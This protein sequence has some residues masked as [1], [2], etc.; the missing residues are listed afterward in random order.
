MLGGKKPYSSV[1]FL[2]CLL[3]LTG[4]LSLIPFDSASPLY[5]PIFWPGNADRASPPRVHF[6][7]SSCP[8]AEI[9]VPLPRVLVG[10]FWGKSTAMYGQVLAKSNVLPGTGLSLWPCW[11]S[12]KIY[13]VFI[14]HSS[15][16]KV[17]SMRSYLHRIFSFFES[18]I[19]LP[20]SL[21]QSLWLSVLSN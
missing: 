17:K 16:W 20:P 7:S 12:A 14:V 10:K 21:E 19:F 15:I 9:K 13:T 8:E 4:F 3:L 6:S 2:T 5:L 1:F 18:L 11:L